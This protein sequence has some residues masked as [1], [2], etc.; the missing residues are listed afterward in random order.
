VERTLDP[1]AQA[2]RASDNSS[3]APAAEP[4]FPLWATA[5]RR[6]WPFVVFLAVGVALA[7]VWR[8]LPWLLWAYNLYQ[9][10]RLMEQGLAWPEPRHVDTLP[11][12]IDSTSLERALGHLSAAIRWRPDHPYAYRLAGRIYLAQ[13]RWDKAAQ[14]FER[15]RALAP[16]HPMADWEAGLAYEQMERAVRTSPSTPLVPRLAFAEVE[17]PDMP[18]DT[19]FCRP[20]NARACYAG[21]TAF[22][23]PYAAAGDSTPVELPTFFLHPP[24]KARLRLEV[25]AEQSALR[26]VL[27][28][29]PEAREWGTDGAT[30][31]VWVEAPD[32]AARLIFERHVSAGEARQGWLL[33]WADLSPWAGREIT[34]VLGTA[35]GPSGNTAGDWYGWGDVA[36]TTPAAARYAAFAPK[37]RQRAA[38]LDGR[39]DGDALL[40]RGD[41]ARRAKRYGEAFAWY[42]RALVT[43][44]TTEGAVFHRRGLAFKAQKAWARAEAA[45]RTAIRAW[46][47]NRD[48]WYELALVL[49]EQGRF[50]EGVEALRQGA[51]APQGTVAP[52]IV[53]LELGR[54]YERLRQ[55]D[56]AKA[57]YEEALARDQF[58]QPAQKN[59]TLY[60]YGVLLKRLGELDRAQ[61]LLS[62]V[63]ERDPNSY[64]SYIHRAE[65][66]W[67]LDRKDE[68]EAMLRQ[69]IELQPNVKW[70]YRSQGLL[71]AR[72]G[73]RD[74]AIPFLRKVLEIDP[75]D[76]QVRNTLENLLAPPQGDQP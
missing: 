5:R 14:A 49:K 56:R 30:F 48:L 3:P 58:T 4:R 22:R 43:F 70:A 39:F 67:G 8:S 26:F 45:F 21:V 19:P 41:E 73:E 6:A 69:A 34:L 37:A 44:P 13:Q 75:N 27:G 76:Q 57:A 18:L 20:G 53:L 51:D 36:L 60:T 54:M 16:L 61:A 24:A 52:S 55:W 66:L 71:Y 15:G 33:G 59:S 17:A 1:Q 7:I 23:L 46:P 12:S 62:E 31:Q 32:E 68:A 72:D 63:I 40:D 28:L 50:R 64:W 65:A 9:A 11:V 42:D 38:W 29:A 47:T 25:P 2:E 74:K 35:G 10:G